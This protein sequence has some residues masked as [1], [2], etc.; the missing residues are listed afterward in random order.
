VAYSLNKVQ[1]IGNLG[2]DPD[3]RTMTSGDR[4]ASFSMAMTESWV[5]KTSNERKKHTEWMTVVCFNQNLVGVIEKYLAKGS[6]VY[7]EGRLQTRKYEKDGQDRYITEV[8][9]QR[10]GGDIITLEKSEGGGGDDRYSS[11]DYRGGGG[12]GDYGNRAQG[13]G[14]KENFAADL[15]DEIPF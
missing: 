7:V 4:V 11:H 1:L 5:D 2:K 6:K 8:V 10:F 12:G 14:P 9:I 3:I 15:D 13:S